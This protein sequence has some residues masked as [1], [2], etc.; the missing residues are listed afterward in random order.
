MDANV[1][2]GKKESEGNE[3]DKVAGG[4]KMKGKRWRFK[5]EEVRKG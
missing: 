4:H 5:E 1:K 2:E 3:G